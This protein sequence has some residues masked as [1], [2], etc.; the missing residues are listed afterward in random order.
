MLW[1]GDDLT[2]SDV[3]LLASGDAGEDLAALLSDAGLEPRPA[4]PGHV[5]WTGRGLPL[6]VLRASAWPSWY[7]SLSGMLRRA[8]PRD[9]SPP[10]AT[11]EDRLL[12]LAAE[13]VGGRPV[14]KLAARARA[15]LTDPSVAERLEALA[16]EERL[17]GL[18]SLVEDPERLRAAAR[19]GRLSYRRA[20]ALAVRIPPAR[21]ALRARL[22]ARAARALGR[23]GAAA[24]RWTLPR[25]ERP[26]LITFSGMDG[27]GKSTAVE[28]VERHLRARG[29]PVHVAWA[30][31]GSEGEV[32]NRLALPV[33]RFLRREGTIAD[34]IAAGGPS[35]PRVQDAREAT[36]R[37]RTMSWAWI[38][39]VAVINARTYRR[40]ADARREGVSVVCDRWAIDALVDLELRY[41]GHWAAR[42]VLRRL[43]PRP[44]LAVLLSL[45]AA[46]AGVRKPG[47][48]AQRVLR[49]MERLYAVRASEDDTVVLD[50]SAPRERVETEVLELVD[51]AVEERAVS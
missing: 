50:A 9:G 36:G 33:K 48:Q 32:L 40:S 39:L 51:R 14:G 21:S 5:V 20:A 34:P 46:T 7:P 12:I 49:E 38:V 47:D 44:D 24:H 29:L 11:A 1:R 25:G 35:T 43:P 19:R 4:E 17:E 10:V 18:A 8:E 31:L 28:A 16:A 41:G 26:L 27:A 6:D 2:G 23:R 15:L 37:R 42:V 30:R 45:D 13:A 22:A 3:D